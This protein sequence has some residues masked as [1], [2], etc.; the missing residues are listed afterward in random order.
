ML[1]ADVSRMAQQ[2]LER[3][4]LFLDTETTGL[5]GQVVD[6]AVLDKCGNVLLDTLVKPNYPME[7]EA[8]NVHHITEEMLVSA[9][10]FEEVWYNGLGELLS[11][12]LVLIYNASFDLG[13][14]HRSA[15]DAN[16]NPILPLWDEVYNT[17]YCNPK[18]QEL[19]ARCLMALAC[20]YFDFTKWQKLEMV[21]RLLG[22]P[23]TEK[24][25][26]RA[27]SDAELARQ[28]CLRIA[29]G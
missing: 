27:K 23:M 3:D 15:K 13:V 2:W 26:H 14:L 29:D 6:I 28:V 11:N 4:P 21:A 5:R 16:H 25:E 12:R 8:Q 17:L 9:P 7:Q 20:H 10:T 1:K 24:Q 19:G 18:P 22:I